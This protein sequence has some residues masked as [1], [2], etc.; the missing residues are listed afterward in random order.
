MLITALVIASLAVTS[1][2]LLAA[3]SH[4]RPLHHA[5]ACQFAKDYRH[6]VHLPAAPC[7]YP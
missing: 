2:V 7:D 3:V 6:E 1:I 5:Y 4:D